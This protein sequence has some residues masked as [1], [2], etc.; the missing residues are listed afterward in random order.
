[1]HALVSA[2]VALEPALPDATETAMAEP[3]ATDG[4]HALCSG[5]HLLHYACEDDPNVAV[6]ERN[7]IRRIQERRAW[8]GCHGHAPGAPKDQERDSV[9]HMRGDVGAGH[10]VLPL[11]VVP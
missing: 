3:N 9:A 1:M 10:T 4:R 2:I 7:A 6:Q 11:H 5:A 8:L